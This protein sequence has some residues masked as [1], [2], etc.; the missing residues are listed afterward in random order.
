MQGIDLPRIFRTSMRE[1]D[2]HTR[3][4]FVRQM[5]FE[6]TS[7]RA[8]YPEAPFQGDPWHFLRPM[9]EVSSDSSP[10][11]RPFVPSPPTFG[12]W[13]LPRICG[14]CQRNWRKKRHFWHCLSIRP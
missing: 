8:A 10:H 6:W 1:L 9:G 2:K 3:L 7:N 4:P 12:R 14:A 11:G 13:R 5:A